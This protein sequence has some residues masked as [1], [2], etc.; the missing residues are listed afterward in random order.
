MAGHR[1]EDDYDYLFK[2]VL[3]GDFSRLTRNEF[4]LKVVLIGYSGVGSP[5][6]SPD[7]LGTSLASRLRDRPLLHV[8]SVLPFW[9]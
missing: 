7:S 5:I 1:A 9:I 2:V 3:I 6:C 4:S 8:P